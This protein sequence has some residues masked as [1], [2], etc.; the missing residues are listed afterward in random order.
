[1]RAEPRSVWNPIP[2]TLTGNLCCP[3][4]PSLKE[5][6]SSS[7]KAYILSRHPYQ[8]TTRTKCLNLTDHHGPSCQPTPAHSSSIQTPRP[9]NRQFGLDLGS[10]R[11]LRPKRNAAITKTKTKT[12]TC[13]ETHYL[14]LSGSH[15][16]RMLPN[17]QETCNLRL[18]HLH[19]NCP[20]VDRPHPNH[21]HLHHLHPRFPDLAPE[22]TN[23]S[24][25][26]NVLCPNLHH[27]K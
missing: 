6:V 24:N 8:H 16:F 4:L 27:A 23:H 10:T 25:V 3:K 14:H 5:H 12:R 21:P 15:L 26:P 7:T 19:P 17:H 20:H 13:L 22:I 1:V 9:K 2:L 11:I 18:I